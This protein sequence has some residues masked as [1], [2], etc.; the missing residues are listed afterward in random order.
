MKERFRLLGTAFV[1][2]LTFLGDIVILN[3]LFVLCSIPIITIGASAAAC[4]AGVSRT[5]QKRET[6][7]VFRAFFADFRAAFRQATA[8]WLLELLVLAVLAGDLWFAVIYSEPDN[9][10]F[11]I[12]AILGCAVVLLA[13]LWFYPLVARFQNTLSGQLKNSFLLAFAQFPKTLLALLVWALFLGVPVVLF[14]VFAYFGWLWLAGGFS[15]PMYLTAKIF[16]KSL[17][18]QPSQEQTAED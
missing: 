3:L 9:T 15:L 12:F 7:L 10:F 14:D 16:R 11:L 1:N 18:L 4:Y 5:L 13:S 2:T 6:G 8:G 17:Q